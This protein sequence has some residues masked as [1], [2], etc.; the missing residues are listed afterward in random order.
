[1]AYKSIKLRKT[2]P[3]ISSMTF[4]HQ[5][6]SRKF[7]KRKSRMTE[8]ILIIETEPSLRETLIS[9][10][11]RAGFSIACVPDYP[12][13]LLWLD[14]SKPDMIILNYT[15]ENSLEICRQL[16][17]AFHIPIILL[18]K[19]SS[20]EAWVEAVQAGADFYFTKPVNHQE[21]ISRVKTILRR[22]SK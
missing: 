8:R 5:E 19:D 11:T 4:L 17:T 2:F 15:S 7:I 14:M 21:I 10:L 6:K 9:T 16:H 12:E 22:Y 18:G 20:G 3:D 13:A 1:M